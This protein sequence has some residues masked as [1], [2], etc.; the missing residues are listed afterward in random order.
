MAHGLRDTG[1]AAEVAGL[2]GLPA[3]VEDRELAADLVRL[4]NGQWWYV[5]NTGD[6]PMAT[7]TAASDLVRRATRSHG[8]TVAEAETLGRTL[9]P[10]DA[11]AG[12]GPGLALAA[13]L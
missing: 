8:V 12:G 2:L 6:H 5:Y 4:L 10:A 7:A 9:S 13:Q 3:G 11:H 1:L